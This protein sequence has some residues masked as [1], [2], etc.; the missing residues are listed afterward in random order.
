MGDLNGHFSREFKIL[1]NYFKIHVLELDDR[2]RIR[3]QLP[4]L[5]YC[6]QLAQQRQRHTEAG[7]RV[8]PA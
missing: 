7:R 6:L 1:Q 3:K 5:F 4:G 8:S 2:H